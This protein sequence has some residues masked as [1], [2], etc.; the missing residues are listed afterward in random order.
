MYKQTWYKNWCNTIGCQI[1][2]AFTLDGNTRKKARFL[3]QQNHRA[4]EFY[5]GFTP[6]SAPEMYVDP[7]LKAEFPEAKELFE[8][9]KATNLKEDFLILEQRID[10]IRSKY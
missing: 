6:D 3:L 5:M 7:E 8:K 1:L 10:F 4:S 2:S 9:Q